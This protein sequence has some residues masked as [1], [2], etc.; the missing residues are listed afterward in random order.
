MSTPTSTD[1]DMTM[2]PSIRW[3]TGVEST[4]M[5]RCAG[6]QEAGLSLSHIES[7]KSKRNPNQF[8]F[9]VN[10]PCASAQVRLW[11]A[12]SHSPLNVLVSADVTSDRLLPVLDRLRT[13]T[14]SVSYVA[15]LNGVPGLAW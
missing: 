2:S 3:P 11:L 9:I 5:H 10:L 6:L 7:R 15:H 4:L 14:S 12:G 13:L 8:E 1:D